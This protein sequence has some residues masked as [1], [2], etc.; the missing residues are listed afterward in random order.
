MI[1]PLAFVPL[2]CAGLALPAAA[3]VVPAPIFGDHMVLQAGVKAPVFGTTEP[4]GVVAISANVVTRDEGG[5]VVGYPSGSFGTVTA[6]DDGRWESAIGPFDA[7]AELWL[8]VAASGTPIFSSG[9]TSEE[10]EEQPDSA[11]R[12]VFTDVLVGDVWLCSGQSNMEWP[13]NNTLDGARD[14][15]AAKSDEIRLFTVPKN[16]V[17][18]PQSTL[19]GQPGQGEPSAAQW[20]KLSPEAAGNFSAVGYHF[21]QTIHNATG[22]PVGLIDSSWGGT[23]SEAWTREETLK[24][25]KTTAPLLE[26]WAGYDAAVA[27]GKETPGNWAG[28][29][30]PTHSHHP[31]NLNN[32]MIAPLVPFAL[33]GAIWYQ[34]ESN[35]DRAEQYDEIFPAM[36]EDWRDQ[37][38][39][40]IPFYWVQ[41]A[42]Y[43]DYQEDPNAASDWAE[44]RE[45]QDNTLEELENVGQ[46]VI[47][48][49]GEAADIHPRNKADVGKRLALAALRDVYG[50]KKSGMSS[51]R[52]KKAELKGN[53]ATIAFETDGDSLQNRR[54]VYDE[55]GGQHVLGFTVAG[56]DKTFYQATAEVTGPDTVRVTAP[57]EVS[58]IAAVRYGWADNPRVTLFNT[59]G[60]PA[61]PFRTDDWPGVTDGKY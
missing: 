52:F 43:R 35:A 1:R 8:I 55:A 17:R 4:G 29:Y 26:R 60:L 18:E 25:L 47:L 5:A 58:E 23:P 50:V 20:V 53:T 40:E 10:R 45:A 28:K 42:N 27:A 51:P 3:E 22:R 36:I 34:G 49:I 37:F 54:D 61:A 39:Q 41:L 30:G 19:K 46:A 24:E 38:G 15:Q 12:K 33:K 56:A 11:D 9:Q 57:A 13:L 21:G 16:S 2:L 31:A 32:G 14:V 48:D 59:R 7:G 6:D 44:L